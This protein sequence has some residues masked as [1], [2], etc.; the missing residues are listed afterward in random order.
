[1]HYRGKDMSLE[2]ILPDGHRELLTRVAPYNWAWQYAYAY[3]EPPVFPAGTMLH[4]I[5][6][7]DN[8]A[9]NRHNPDPGNW[10]GYGQRTVDEMSM[11]VTNLVYLSDEEYEQISK[12][13]KMRTQQH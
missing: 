1:M 10:V 13:A 7:H 9:K 2:A 6:H 12:A 4:V 11:G 8:S 3:Q 5:A